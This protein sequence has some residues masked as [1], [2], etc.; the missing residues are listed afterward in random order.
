M[1]STETT[2]ADPAPAS[3]EPGPLDSNT[4]RASLVMLLAWAVSSGWIQLTPEEVQAVA[5]GLV[6]LMPV[7][8]IL[9]RLFKNQGP[10]KLTR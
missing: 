9:L 6:G 7:V 8:I 3:P 10:I 1:T 4:I 5:A 2:T